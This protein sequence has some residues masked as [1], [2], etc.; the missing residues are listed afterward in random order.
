M[1]HKWRGI[2]SNT[3]IGIRGREIKTK[4]LRYNQII[5]LLLFTHPLSLWMVLPWLV[6]VVISLLL[7]KLLLL[8]ISI[9]WVWSIVHCL[10]SIV[11]LLLLL[12]LHLQWKIRDFLERLEE[13]IEGDALIIVFIEDS[14]GAFQLF[15]R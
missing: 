5:I 13:F 10:S 1:E 9:S 6:G 12:S 14:E 3:N 2:L 4:Q 11:G 8:S 15:F 7:L